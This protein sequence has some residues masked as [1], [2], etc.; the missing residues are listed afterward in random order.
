[1]KKLDIELTAKRISLLTKGWSLIGTEFEIIDLSI[2]DDVTM[3]WIYN[4]STL[5]W[6]AY[7]SNS[8]IKEKIKNDTDIELITRIPTKS[9]IWIQK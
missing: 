8:S 2:F 3:I 9:G 5:K 7:S 6:G 1:V 4:N